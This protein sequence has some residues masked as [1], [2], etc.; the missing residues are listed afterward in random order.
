ML[1]HKYVRISLIAGFICSLL[2][3]L[4][5]FTFY[6][7]NKN[8]LLHMSTYD[9]LVVLVCIGLA[10][11][12]YRDKW[13]AGK[14]SFWEAAKIGF[15]TNLIGTFLS[16]FAIYIFIAFIDTEV[17]S[18]H[19]EDLKNI[20]LQT[21]EQIYESFGK[22]AYAETMKNLQATTP[23]DEALDIFIKKFLVCLLATGFIAAILRKNK[24]QIM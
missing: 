1:Q 16:T 17:L 7:L 18:K 2:V 3:L 14:L 15:F 13:N 9:M 5:F 20:L 10:M 24:I 8:P 6:F 4:Y 21:K 22:E 12:V 19:I 11:G 23:L